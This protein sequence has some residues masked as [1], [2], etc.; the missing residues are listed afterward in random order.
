MMME[1]ALMLFWGRYDRRA[2]PS[3]QV[4]K[5]THPASTERA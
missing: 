5:I 2:R 4:F 1:V 3:E